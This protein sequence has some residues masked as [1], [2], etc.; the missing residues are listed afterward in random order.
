M[1]ILD[2]ISSV[3]IGPQNATKS[4][5]AEASPQTPLGSLQRSPVPP[6]VFKGAYF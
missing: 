1:H 4:L 3:S 5:A 2:V 6:V